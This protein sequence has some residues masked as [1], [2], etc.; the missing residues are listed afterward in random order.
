M[1]NINFFKK[2]QNNEFWKQQYLY[3]KTLYIQSNNS[4]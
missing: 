1:K 3:T 2:V 4:Q